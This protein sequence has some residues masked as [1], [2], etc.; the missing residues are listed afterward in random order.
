MQ[1]TA[2]VDQAIFELPRQDGIPVLSPMQ[3]RIE[4]SETLRVL[5]GQLEQDR[6][7]GMQLRR[8]MNSL[9]LLVME[10]LEDGLLEDLLED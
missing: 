9:D 10:Q 5:R 3:K 2:P 6:A 7:G 4:R 8:A 1:H